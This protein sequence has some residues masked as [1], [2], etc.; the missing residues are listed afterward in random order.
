MSSYGTRA[1]HARRP[2]F[3]PASR[4]MARLA[5]ERAGLLVVA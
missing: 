1:E 2:S 4:L 5:A 3:V